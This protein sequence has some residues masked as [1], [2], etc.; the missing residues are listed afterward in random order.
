MVN[1]SDQFLPH[2]ETGAMFSM[3]SMLK[4]HKDFP[5]QD[6]LQL[7]MPFPLPP[8]PVKA[9]WSHAPPSRPSTYAEMTLCETA[10]RAW[11]SGL[12]Y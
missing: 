6:Q 7:S 9:L 5:P 8:S 1:R 3:S 2:L 4:K 12:N 10:D 11:S